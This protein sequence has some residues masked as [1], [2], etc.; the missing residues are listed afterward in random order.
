MTS[1]EPL[2]ECRSASINSSILSAVISVDDIHAVHKINRT[3]A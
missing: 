1:T 3:R 2:E